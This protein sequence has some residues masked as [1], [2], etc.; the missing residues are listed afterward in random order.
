MRALTAMSV[1][2]FFACGSVGPKFPDA[3]PPTISLCVG[4]RSS[5]DTIRSTDGIFDL[6]GSDPETGD[7]FARLRLG[8]EAL[9]PD[10]PPGLHA[11]LRIMVEGTAEPV[12]DAMLVLED[13]GRKEFRLPYCDFFRPEGVVLVF[14]IT[15]IDPATG[16]AVANLYARGRIG[17]FYE[18]ELE[19]CRA[20]CAG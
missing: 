15:V 10:V 2:T 3:G 1:C 16:S 11:R 20:Q 6:R 17:C 7:W 18:P 14:E 4:Y 13:D 9:E 5:C 19:T 8:R 12:F